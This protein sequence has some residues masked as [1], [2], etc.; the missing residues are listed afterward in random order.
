V[1]VL[2]AEYYFID[3]RRLGPDGK[4]INQE[5]VYEIKKH[6]LIIM[7]ESGVKK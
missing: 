6:K 2:G 4:T 7:K 1:E 5:I 3:L